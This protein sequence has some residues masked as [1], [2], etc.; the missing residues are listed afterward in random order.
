MKPEKETA[1]STDPD[2]IIDVPNEALP[3]D[4]PSVPA[5]VT[6]KTSAMT[7]VGHESCVMNAIERLPYLRMKIAYAVTQG[8]PEGIPEGSLIATDANGAVMVLASPG[9]PVDIIL[10]RTIMYYK[11]WLSSE[12]FSAGLRPRTFATEAEANA[13]GLTTRY[14]NGQVA[15]APPAYD[16]FMLVRKPENYDGDTSSFIPL[17]NELWLPVLYTADKAGARSVATFMKAL[18]I[19]RTI[20][21]KSK[22]TFYDTLCTLTIT[23]HVDRKGRKAR[24]PQIGVAIDSNTNK[25]KEPPKEAIEDFTRLI[26]ELSEIDTPPCP[27]DDMPF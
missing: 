20:T 17:G 10:L 26:K 25:V 6:A 9:K 12:K 18:I 23:A 11:E 27:D 21:G 22:T 24:L 7:T 14:I 3:E 15:G 4:P 5:T 13:A 1:L 19:R 16:M 2:N 8:L